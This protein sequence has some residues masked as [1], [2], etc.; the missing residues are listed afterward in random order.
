MRSPSSFLFFSCIL[1]LAFPFPAAAA[2]SNP[3]LLFSLEECGAGKTAL[4]STNMTG[5]RIRSPSWEPPSRESIFNRPLSTLQSMVGPI[6]SF[7][8]ADIE[9]TFLDKAGKRIPDSDIVVVSG[10]DGASIRTALGAAADASARES[11]GF[12]GAARAFSRSAAKRFAALVVDPMGI[13]ST[14]ASAVREHVTDIAAPVVETLRALLVGTADVIRSM[15][16]DLPGPEG[17][18]Q[19]AAAALEAAAARPTT[20]NS[21]SPHAFLNP[22]EGGFAGAT[23]VKKAAPPPAAVRCTLNPFSL[24][25]PIA[26]SV[27]VLLSLNANVLSSSRYFLFFSGA[28]LG[29]TLVVVV[30]TVI[31]MRM[32]RGKRDFLGAAFLT[33]AGLGAAASSWRESLRVLFADIPLVLTLLNNWW[34]LL[35]AVALFGAAAAAWCC[36]HTRADENPLTKT[37]IAAGLRGI[38][39]L[40]ILSGSQSRIVNTLIAI[41]VVGGPLGG[42]YIAWWLGGALLR[43][44]A[45]PETLLEFALKWTLGWCFTTPRLRFVRALRSVFG[46]GKLTRTDTISTTNTNTNDV[47]DMTTTTATTIPTTRAAQS[48]PPQPPP[49]RS[50]ETRPSTTATSSARWPNSWPSQTSTRVVYGRGGESSSEVEEVV[51]EGEGEEPPPPLMTP[52]LQLR[53]E[54]AVSKAR[55]SGGYAGTD[56]SSPLAPADLQAIGT[57]IAQQLAHEVMRLLSPPAPPPPPPAPSPG[58]R[59]SVP[60]QCIP[61]PRAA[62]VAAPVARS[63]MLPPTPSAPEW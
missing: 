8:F 59:Y 27:G 14:S 61:P 51:E 48:Q 34:I 13:F 58:S 44:A 22:L 5:V 62:S 36:A 38:A 7:A 40:S 17:W 33:L 49:P 16:R 55:L 10:V 63:M 18:P 37:Y 39:A 4:L 31:L 47:I 50:I 25:Y 2:A 42:E 9:V 53:V 3:W 30:V 26:L 15:E 1:T 43:A 32:V 56:P 46:C 29:A 60:P 20:I 6:A 52:E 54:R 11:G 35:V 21:P 19:A 57:N 28:A 24:R 45:A 41:V 12:V 23:S